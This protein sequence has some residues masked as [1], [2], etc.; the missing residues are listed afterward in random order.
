MLIAYTLG[1]VN[2]PP[3]SLTS[4]YQWLLTNSNSIGR[5]QALVTEP[6]EVIMLP[7][8]DKVVE[9]FGESTTSAFVAGIDSLPGERYRDK[10]RQLPPSLPYLIV[11][12]GKD[13]K[14]FAF[15]GGRHCLH[16]LGLFD[17]TRKAA[18]LVSYTSDMAFEV[19]AFLDANPLRFLT[20]RF[21]PN[22]QFFFVQAEAISSKWQRWSAQEK[23]LAFNALEARLY[24][25]S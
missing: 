13:H 19:K 8:R 21:S 20:Y 1:G 3:L 25:E 24:H 7:A 12:L 5:L 14:S 2:P 4:N 11:N 9:V 16:T 10:L 15:G 17:S 18:Y 22:G 6:R 23:L